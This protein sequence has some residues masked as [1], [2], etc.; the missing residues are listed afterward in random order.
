MDEMAKAVATPRSSNMVLLGAAAPF[1]DIDEDKIRDGIRNVF[2]RKSAEIIESNIKAFNAG[3]NK[4][5][6]I[7]KK[8]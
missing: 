2:A 3:L 5:Q 7:T 4:A 6:E 1:I 8:V